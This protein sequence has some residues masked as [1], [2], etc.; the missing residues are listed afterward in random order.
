MRKLIL[1]NL[2]TA[3]MIGGCLSAQASGEMT[4]LGEAYKV[5]TV[6]HFK[7]GPGTTTTSL[8]LSGP[9]KLNVHYLT[10]DKTTPGVKLHT[11]CST[12]KVAGT[13]TTSSMAKRKSND[14]Q[15][16]FAGING[17]FL[18]HQATPLTV[19]QSWELPV[20]QLSLTANPSKPKTAN[21]R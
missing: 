21:I 18:R 11:V 9:R 13:E 14:Q 2:M 19:R 16:Y 6:A 4:V 8:K 7:V 15:T 3:F 17:D 12:D 20:P 5:D 10:I 1:Y